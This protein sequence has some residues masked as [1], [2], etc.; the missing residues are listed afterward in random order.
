M[1]AIPSALITAAQGGRDRLSF[2]AGTAAAANLQ[3]KSPA[4]QGTM[5]S[6]AREAIF[7]DA[8]LSAVHA[9]LE[10]LRSVT[11]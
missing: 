7:T 4:A 5:A 11:K 9:R 6:A 10:E 8:L 3:A 2:L 1:D